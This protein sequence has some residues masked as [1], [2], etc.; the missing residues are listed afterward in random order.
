MTQISEVRG[1]D[2][3]PRRFREAEERGRRIARGLFLFADIGKEVDETLMERLGDAL[4]QR[5]E[6][7]AALA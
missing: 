6:L 3:F 1:T 7:G 4:L 2:R 5:D